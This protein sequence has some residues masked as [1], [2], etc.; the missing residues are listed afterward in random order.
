MRNWRSSPSSCIMTLPTSIVA[1][2][3][4]I[5]LRYHKQEH[6]NLSVLL[7]GL[8]KNFASKQ[9]LLVENV[10]LDEYLADFWKVDIEVVKQKWKGGLSWATWERASSSSQGSV[11]T[12]VQS[13]HLQVTW[14]E[15]IFDVVR[16]PV[17]DR[18][19]GEVQCW[20][21][22][23][24]E[25]PDD[26][27]GRDFYGAV[28]VWNDA[29][30]GHESQGI[31]VFN[32]GVWK[33]DPKLTE[34]IEGIEWEDI[35]LEEKVLKGLQWDVRSFF[36]NKSLY[37]DLKVAWKR[38][39]LLT[40][41]PGNGKSQ[42]IKLL[43]KEYSSLSCL[44]VKS[45]KGNRHHMGGEECI[46][47]IFKKARKSAPCLLVLEDLDTLIED[48][49]RTFF[50]NEVDGF[51][52]NNGILI[53]ASS[54]HPGRIDPAIT[55][56][57]RFDAIYNFERPDLELRRAYAT[58][59]LT[60]INALHNDNFLP[61]FQDPQRLAKEIAEKTEAFSFAY[62]KELFLGFLLHYA[63][64]G[65]GDTNSYELLFSQI[66]NLKKQLKD[67]YDEKG[68]EKEK[69]PGTGVKPT[70]RLNRFISRLELDSQRS[71]GAQ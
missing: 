14:R 23:V 45:T 62:M 22:L 34:E 17:D 18:F 44:Y 41:P 50:L 32:Q 52:R 3:E 63:H 10:A 36:D 5:L 59:W 25:G 30:K 29:Q 12:E 70:S 26:S 13:G 28:S 68:K 39:L 11:L 46:T 47:T 38:G 58:K 65:V 55:R 40:G 9:L 31:L 16:V 61:S 24:F 69:A 43:V 57:S 60:K 66:S 21:A 49:T 33:K 8:R 54:N 67:T 7:D 42:T 71:D 27:V 15:V 6:P 56:P 2:S 19:T 53:L 37:E 4:S 51:A 64:S 48:D 35:V 20:C 1:A